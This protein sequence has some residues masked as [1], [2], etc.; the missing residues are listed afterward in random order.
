MRPV[1]LEGFVAETALGAGYQ[2]LT[3]LGRQKT[4]TIKISLISND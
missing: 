4:L 1:G 2:K 3:S